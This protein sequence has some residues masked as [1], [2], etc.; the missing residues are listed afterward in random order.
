VSDSAAASSRTSRWY[1]TGEVRDRT[2]RR[3]TRSN[4]AADSSYGRMFLEDASSL[5][6]YGNGRDEGFTATISGSDTTRTTP[7]ITDALPTRFASRALPS[8]FRDFF[9]TTAE[10]MLTYGK[11]HY[12][13]VYLR[14]GAEG[15]AGPPSAF[16]FELIPPGS[17]HRRRGQLVQYVPP[18]MAQK[19]TRKGAGI[20]PLQSDAVIEFRLA[21]DLARQLR[22]TLRALEVGSGQTLANVS[23]LSD[24]ASGELRIGFKERRRQADQ[25]LA[26]ATAPTGWDGRGLLRGEQLDPYIVWRQLEFLAF[27]IQLRQTILDRLNIALTAAG[28][29]LDFTAGIDIDGVPALSDVRR[30]QQDLEHGYQSLSDLLNWAIQ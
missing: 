25:I 19:H 6:P 22:R 9:S 30:R 24:P 28:R 11:A 7:L 26:R 21:A 20:I 3:L 18:H 8:R 2:L 29:Q 4:R 23:M 14:Q 10:L 1:Y 13:L 15:A 27:K 5:L 12:E 17:V 16:R